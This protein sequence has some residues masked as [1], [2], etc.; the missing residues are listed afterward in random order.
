MTDGLMLLIVFLCFAISIA[1]IKGCDRIV[2]EKKK[3]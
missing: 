2:N 1:F 3:E